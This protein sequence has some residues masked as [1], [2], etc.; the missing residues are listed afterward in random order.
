ME[1]NETL[2]NLKKSLHQNA[3]WS[4]FAIL[5]KLLYKN[6][7]QHKSSQH[8][9]RLKLACRLMNRLKEFQM[10]AAFNAL[11]KLHPNHHH[12][13]LYS[14]AKRLIAMNELVD[15][16]V[17]ASKEA[18]ISFR[19][20]ASMTFFMPVSFSVMACLAK[21]TSV[22]QIYQKDVI[23]ECYEAIKGLHDA[24]PGSI[25]DLPDR[26]VVLSGDMKILAEEVDI[27]ERDISIPQEPV[28]TELTASFWRDTEKVVQETT[29]STSVSVGTMHHLDEV[30]RIARK[31]G[32]KKG[33][34]KQQLSKG[35]C[36]EIDEIFGSL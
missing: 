24:I 21:I 3:L 33:K 17:F 27:V 18:Y 14:L 31:N 12:T 25:L 7:S 30:N 13:E 1:I 22:I 28:D 10:D 19:A 5:L 16:I 4:E 29:V 15:Q 6:T 20:V 11:I 32:K 36:S 2:A 9:R 23:P 34:R 35:S 26:V 8:F